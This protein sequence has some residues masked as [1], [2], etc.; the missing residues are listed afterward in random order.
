MDPIKLIKQDHLAVKTLFRDFGRAGKRAER[1][2]IAEQIIEELSVHASVEEQ[3]LYPLLRQNDERREPAVLDALE[4]HH[5]AK[6]ILAELDKMDVD[7]ERYDA[8]MHVVESTVTLHIEEEERELLPRLLRLLDRDQ[9]EALAQDIVRLKQAVPD[10]PHPMA[11]DTPP[12]GL[13][14]GMVAKVGDAAKDVMRK[15]TSP[16][17]AEGHRRVRRRAKQ[18]QAQAAPRG[19]RAGSRR[20][21]RG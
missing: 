20:R 2:A 19:R 6:L 17:R 14:A 1:Q 7:D 4:E 10:H 13:V 18:Q 15:L 16:A 9:A 8:K 21:R 3:L 5:A 12:A 11:P